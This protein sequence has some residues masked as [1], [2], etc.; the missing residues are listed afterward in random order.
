MKTIATVQ[1]K[2]KL[3]TLRKKAHQFGTEEVKSKMQLLKKLSEFS[4][5]DPSMLVRYHNMLLFILAYPENRIIHRWALREL[6]RVAQ[7]ITRIYTG[8][9]RKKKTQLTNSGIANSML[10]VS[11]SFEMVKWLQEKFPDHISISS[12][13]ADEETIRSAFIT[14]LLKPEADRFREESFS[15]EQLIRNLRPNNEVSDLKWLINFFGNISVSPEVRDHLYN[16]LK[17]FISLSLY[18]SVPSFAGAGAR[19]H[20][21][22]FHQ[23]G[24]LKKFDSLKTIRDKK[25][26]PCKL[27]ITEKE[28]LL[29]NARITLCMHQREIDPVTFANIEEMELFDMGRGI[30]VA[31]FPMIPERKLS[32]E[33]YIGYMAFKNGIPAAYGG[34]WIYLFHSKI[35]INIFPALRG[36]ES[37]YLFCQILRLY[38]H[39]FNVK[40]FIVEPY[41][42]GKNNSE[43]IKSGAYWFYYRLGFRSVND[44]LKNLAASEFEKIKT[45]KQYRAPIAVMKQL[46]K[47]DLEFN[48]AANENYP[49]A[50]AESVSESITQL[51]NS[52]FEGNRSL[53][54][55]VDLPKSKQGKTDREAIFEMQKL[56]R[57]AK[58]VEGRLMKIFGED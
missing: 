33:S 8:K 34:G 58:N 51:V 16:S 30:D 14:G 52:H 21:I 46:A 55:K 35:G 20:K 3:E 23:N 42:I 49:D 57:V 27:P 12:C 9:N 6:S 31:L 43:G 19:R 36:G 44:E 40:K 47:S 48:L 37:S 1:L 15:L 26:K 2:K 13:D 18:E 5:T 4:I 10:N 53:V 41:Q 22:F 54:T 38:H 17:I 7:S 11:F 29:T 32:L 28:A 39:H 24:L 25:I 45:K 56:A 50:K